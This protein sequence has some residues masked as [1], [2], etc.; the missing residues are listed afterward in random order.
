MQKPIKILWLESGDLYTVR[1]GI[2]AGTMRG[3]QVDHLEILDLR[4]EVT[5]RGTEVVGP[6]GNLTDTYDAVII[7]SFMPWVSESLTIAR[8]FAECGKVVT[9]AALVDE[10]YGMSKIHDYALLGRAGVAVPRTFQCFDPWEAEEAQR[11]VGY[12]CILKGIHGAEGRHVH[13]A[14]TPAQFRKRL[15]QYKI[16]ELMVQEFLDAEVDYRA[17]CVGYASLP[18]LVRRK[19]KPGDFRTNFEHQEEVTTVPATDMPE[20]VRLA[21][22]AARSLRREFSGVDIRFRGDV[23]VVLEANRRPGFKAF[24]ETTGFDVAGTF[25]DY[26]AKRVRETRGA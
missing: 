8:L 13:K 12:P 7:R 23:P 20:V 19:P 16:G 10:G 3:H 9:D 14:D 21:E 4:F 22:T 25:I 6:D 2:E 15:S 24:E 26:V 5:T 1:R 18:V 11:K 17:I